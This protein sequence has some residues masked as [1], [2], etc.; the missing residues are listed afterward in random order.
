MAKKGT[1]LSQITKNKIRAKLKGR[2]D[3]PSVILALRRRRGRHLSAQ[4]K[5]AISAGIKRF[6]QTH[7]KAK[8]KPL[9]AARLLKLRI[10]QLKRRL[11]LHRPAKRGSSL[12]RHRIGMGVQLHHLQNRKRVPYKRKKPYSRF[13]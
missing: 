12:H 7:Q 5:S 9:T 6:R 3:K 8:R 2:K 13:A 11:K 10:Y 1:H 4:T